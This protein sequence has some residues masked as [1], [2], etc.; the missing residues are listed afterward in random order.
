YAIQ[1]ELATRAEAWDAMFQDWIRIGGWRA[2]LGS[3]PIAEAVVAFVR[4]GGFPPWDVA[5]FFNA[6]LGIFIW[7]KIRGW[8][9]EYRHDAPPKNASIERTLNVVFFLRHL[10]V[11]YIILCDGIIIV[12]VLRKLPIPQISWH[13]LP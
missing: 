5:I 11:S 8:A 2:R 6:I 9:N 13:F 4:P 12:R 10:L 3:S 7:L 1:V